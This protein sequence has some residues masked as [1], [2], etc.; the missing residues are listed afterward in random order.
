MGNFSKEKIDVLKVPKRLEKFVK[1]VGEEEIGGVYELTKETVPN[2]KMYV[3][4]TI[5]YC[6]I[7]RILVLFLEFLLMLRLDVKK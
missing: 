2:E 3:T 1:G 4:L 7:N 5:N 6:S